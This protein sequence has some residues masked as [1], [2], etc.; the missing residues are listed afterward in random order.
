MSLLK[1][2]QHPRRMLVLLAMAAGTLLAWPAS[3]AA[4]STQDQQEI[5]YLRNLFQVSSS[6]TSEA[7]LAQL[8]DSKLIGPSIRGEIA[9]AVHGQDAIDDH[10]VDQAVMEGLS[11]E[12]GLVLS[13]DSFADSMLSALGP[14]LP[15]PAELLVG[16]HTGLQEISSQ[17]PLFV[18]ALATLYSFPTYKELLVLFHQAREEGKSREEVEAAMEEEVLPALAAVE[19]T[20]SLSQAQ[21]FAQYN[22]SSECMSLA[23]SSEER[24]GYAEYVA[25]LI[26]ALR[27]YS[28]AEGEG[29]GGL[30]VVAT[31]SQ[32][33]E[34]I[35]EGSGLVT[36]L[37]LRDEGGTQI[38][39]MSRLEPGQ[40]VAVALSG[41]EPSSVS[42]AV[43]GIEG[44][45]RPYSEL[46]RELYVGEPFA[47][48]VGA[49][50]RTQELGVEPGPFVAAGLTPLFKWE[51]GDG[52]P[53]ASTSTATH[54]YACYGQSVAH[55][56][57]SAGGQS[58]TRN[59]TI[60]RAP[61]F[62]IEWHT[63]EGELS[64][65][66]GVP[67]TFVADAS[68]PQ[69]DTVRWSFGDG[70]NATGREVSH[71]FAS[72]GRY[73]V[74]MSVEVAGA[75]CQP[76]LA[77]HTVTV[78][79]SEEWIPLGGTIGTARL[80]SSVAGYVILGPLTVASGHTLTIGPGVNVKFERATEGP[81]QLLVDGSLK[82]EGAVGAPAVFTS[83]FDD[84]A[85]GHCSCAPQG[86]APQPDDWYGITVL[87]SATIKHADIRYADNDVDLQ[88]T[89][90]SVQ[91]T[92]SVLS[93]AGAGLDSRGANDITVQ[94]SS[95]AHDNIGMSLACFA[96]SYSPKL[97]GDVFSEDEVGV[98]VSGG[99]APRADHS[100]FDGVKRAVE[101]EVSAA[102]TLLTNTT[103]KGGGGFVV[104]YGGLFPTGST[105]LASDLP[106]VLIG[107]STIQ[108]T[109]QLTIGPHT[110]VRFAPSGFTPGRLIDDGSLILAGSTSAPATLTSAYDESDGGPCGCAPPGH[111]P[112][113]G[114]WS[115][116]SLEAGARAYLQNAELRYAAQALQLRGA[117][118]YAQVTGSTIEDSGA[119]L[120]STALSSSVIESSTLR[121]DEYGLEMPCACADSA[122][123]TDTRFPSVHTGAYIGGQ[124]Q[125][126]IHD[127]A[128]EAGRQGI[129]AVEQAS[130]DA[131]E[132]WWGAPSGPSPTGAGAS[133]SGDVTTV[134]YCTNESCMEV[135]LMLGSSTLLADGSSQTTATVT[136]T[137]AGVP[138]AGDRVTLSSSDPEEKIGPLTDNGDGTYTATITSSHTLGN[139]TI[140]AVDAS[141]SPAAEAT[142]T[143]TQIAPE[144]SVSVSPATIAAGG[145]AQT[146][147]TVTITGPQG[148]LAGEPV[149]ISSSDPGQ[150]I[151]PVSEAG[152]GTYTA[153]ITSSATVGATTIIA[154]D[155]AYGAAATASTTLY[156]ALKRHVSL[157]LKPASF[158]A[159]T[160]A[161][162]TATI[163]VTAG[164]LP[165][166]GDQIGLAS[167]DPDMRIGP[168]T[169]GLD[170][171]Y[172]ATITASPTVGAASI[173]ATDET[174]SPLATATATLHQRA[175]KISVSLQPRRIQANGRATTMI[176]VKLDAKKAPVPG[177]DILITSSDPEEKIGPIT[178]ASEG[179][180]TAQLTASL[181]PG[182]VTITAR[183]LSV[184]ADQ[185]SAELTQT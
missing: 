51:F 41:G 84:S 148:P 131:T 153:T 127:S 174:V 178:E 45:E 99:A 152:D 61:P 175:P 74:K 115:G 78:G 91:V 103:V 18:K 108:S 176:T 149:T 185:A 67:L 85:G 133:V 90:A 101:G 126:Q 37:Q 164:G 137:A 138:R 181:T 57:A 125:L 79:R 21:L 116:V 89:G 87:G 76:L 25:A 146:L 107:E 9:C 29:S 30:A 1:E 3:A 7:E 49:D 14:L 68:I 50:S 46:S 32:S 27:T 130:A 173:T 62:D 124:A 64:V 135:A 66:P 118:A 142:A 111:T 184:S 23:E 65:A 136:V 52:T 128:F 93:D 161:T 92:E 80:S 86:Q 106:Y 63:T 17:V 145:T 147:A 165:V 4:I 28:N 182:K 109:S 48:A 113:A 82:V 112:A 2:M 183:D 75:T 43:D 162:S 179:V 110:V 159:G 69:E 73:E 114:D 169:E 121:N 160:G 94:S 156:Q 15:A 119:A 59:L 16:V 24:H 98:V 11:G 150:T 53:T 155:E 60:E 171:T 100:E 54:E 157:H 8:L 35:D 19:H 104:L 72:S 97:E 140:A 70:Q 177:Q 172:T 88:G 170:G 31:G 132:N 42:F 167:S 12:L 77:S 141:V 22:Y 105:W 47:R 36:N 102:R 83:R 180:Y 38:G 151:G 71:A 5:G 81:G 134:P 123:L 163:T 44:A 10:E 120:S 96:C 56:S 58:A 13:A 166:S 95:F 144:V 20:R 26:A 122:K 6:S 143:L 154:R 158:V 168:V 34:V 139:A 39:G 33:V 55:F 117:D 129:V 40:S